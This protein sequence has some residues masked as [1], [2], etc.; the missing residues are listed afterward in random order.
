MSAREATSN[1]ID[2]SNADGALYSTSFTSNYTR[3]RLVLAVTQYSASLIMYGLLLCMRMYAISDQKRRLYAIFIRLHMDH[4]F[5]WHKCVNIYNT[6]NDDI[7]LQNYISECI[8][9]VTFIA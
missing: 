3:T 8:N 7:I 9:T 2:K 1:A 5:T 6:R 4:V